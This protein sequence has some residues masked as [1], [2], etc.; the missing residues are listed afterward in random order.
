VAQRRADPSRG[1]YLVR[2][3]HVLSGDPDIGDVP[4]GDVHVR[5]GVITA[6]APEI[7]APGAEVIDARDCVVM[8]GF[9]EVHWH[10]WNSI[11]RGMSHDAVQYFG[12]HRLAHFYTPDD[13]YTA[14]RYAAL[15]AV[16]A[17]ITTCHNWAH[18]IR[19]FTDAEAEMRALADSGLRARFG[20]GDAPEQ[21]IG[22][23]ELERAQAWLADHG[24]RRI[25]LGIAIQ[26]P[27]AFADQVAAARELGL[28]TIAPHADYSRHLDL[29]GPDFLYTHGAGATAEEIAFIA[30]N[31]LKV[32]LCPWTD[33]LVGAGLPPLQEMLDGGVPFDDIAFSVDVTCQAAADP[34]TAMRML[35]YSA[36][37]AQRPGTSFMDVV[38]QDKFGDGPPQPLMRPRQ[39]LQLATLNGARVLGL[40]AVTGS[41][42][43]GKRADLILVRTD[44]VNMLPAPDCDPGFQLVQHAQPS[45]VDTVIADGRV[46]KRHG[47]LLDDATAVIAAAA[48]AQTAIR[49]RARAS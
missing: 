35:L 25:D 13:H 21:S 34:F 17:G 18:G 1:E 48:A 49:E 38:V 3:G 6:V 24:D 2:G 42:T 19:D 43:P 26:N 44:H 11:W 23:P 20:Y 39:V 31:G 22:V 45:N 30:A 4:A 10:M 47:R 9:V 36:R 37:I 12:L 28:K 41:L 8:P 15:E 29:A 40:D 32:G 5:D 33:P 7:T 27:V 16:N 14:V 46:L